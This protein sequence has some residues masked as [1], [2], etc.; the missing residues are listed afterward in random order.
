MLLFRNKTT[1][2][3]ET[4]KYPLSSII[5]LSFLSSNYKKL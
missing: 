1:K 5:I 2:Q 3:A 4:P